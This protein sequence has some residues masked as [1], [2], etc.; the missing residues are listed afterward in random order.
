MVRNCLGIY[1]W[2]AGRMVSPIDVVAH[3]RLSTLWAKPNRAPPDQSLA[4]R[5]FGSN[6]VFRPV[7]N[8]RRALAHALVAA[9]FALHPLHVESVVWIAERRDVLS[10]FFFMLT[11]GAYGEYVRHP[12][13]LGRYLAVVVFFALGLMAKSMLVTLPPLLL[14]L[15]Y[16]PLGRF[17]RKANTAALSERQKTSARSAQPPFPCA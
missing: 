11:L 15:D 2:P 7:A 5:R 16:W 10:A 12:A 17:G 9:L 13:S 4:A 8:D 3:A 6:V 1:Q 14:L